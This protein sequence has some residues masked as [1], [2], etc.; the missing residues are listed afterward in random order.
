M[1]LFSF[2][3]NA[4]AKLF[5]G[6]T[7]EE[8]THTLENSYDKVED[9]IRNM[10]AQMNLGIDNFNVTYNAGNATLTGEAHTQA[11][12]EKVVLTVGNLSGVNEVDDQ[13]TVSN[14]EGESEMEADFYV[15]ESGDTLSKIA[16]NH[17]G[18]ANRYNDI[19]EANRPMLSHPDKIYPGQTL[20]IPR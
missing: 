16:K 11:D 5:G 14:V 18:D 3:K 7:K 12:R 1:G 6:K 9:A 8:E 10:V 13:M 2:I 17:Y 4:G 20:R 19:F 15:V